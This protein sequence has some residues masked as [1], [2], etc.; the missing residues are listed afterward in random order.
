MRNK[1]Q[2]ILGAGVLFF[3]LLLLI[4]N[5]LGLSIWRF[6]WPMVLIAIGVL[7]ILRQQSS[8]KDET[9]TTFGFARDITRHGTWEINNTDFW[10]FAADLDLD[11]TKAI[12]P[13]GQ[14]Q[15]KLYGFVHEIRLRVPKEVGVAVST[16][17]FVTEK[18][19]NG[20]NEDL[21]LMPLNWQ[22]ENYKSAANKFNIEAN[23]F[24]VD[25]RII[26]DINGV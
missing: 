24:V 19:I 18:K 26:E 22:S 21:I 15:W 2:L 5:F 17:A 6:I 1:G 4:A 3:G 13:E 10:H 12:I 7:I 14:H 23:G 9:D 20:E 16:H 11:L 25:V 8:K